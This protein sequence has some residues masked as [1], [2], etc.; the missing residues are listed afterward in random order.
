MKSGKAWGKSKAYLAC[1]TIE[2]ISL[3]Y[4]EHVVNTPKQ[5]VHKIRRTAGEKPPFSPHEFTLD[6]PD[7]LNLQME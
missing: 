3:K 2:I 6:P 7:T 4:I 5:N 1:F